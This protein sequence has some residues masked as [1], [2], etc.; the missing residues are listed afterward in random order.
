MKTGLGILTKAGR[1]SVIQEIEMLDFLAK[2]LGISYVT[3][4][5]QGAAHIDGF[6][7]RDGVIIA[8]YESKCRVKWE[9]YSSLLI[10]ATKIDD[11]VAVSSVLFVPFFVLA[12][13]V[14]QRKVLLWMVTDDKGNLRFPIERRV[15]N[16]QATITGGEASR[17][18]AFLPITQAIVMNMEQNGEK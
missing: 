2:K 17:M 12:H 15:T 1:E 13:L 16:T 10:T 3:V 14:N 4:S 18:N 8:A 5:K 6:F 11:G 9:D 7:V